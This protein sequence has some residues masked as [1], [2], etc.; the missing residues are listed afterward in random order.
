MSIE[1]DSEKRRRQVAGSFVIEMDGS[2][3][4]RGTENGATSA[5][6]APHVDNGKGADQLPLIAEWPYC[7]SAF[8][9]RPSTSS[10]SS[11]GPCT[12]T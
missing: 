1:Q 10:R 9:S 2:L 7:R 4:L 6:G 12:L 11:R 5:T 8:V 3:S